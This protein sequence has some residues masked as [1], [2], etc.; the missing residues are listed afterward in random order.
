MAMS[1]NEREAEMQ[2]RAQLEAFMR[3]T[4][5][6]AMHKLSKQKEKSNTMIWELMHNEKLTDVER[7]ALVQELM[8][9]A[10]EAAKKFTDR[11]HSIEHIAS[12]T[13]ADAH[14]NVASVAT[15]M[16]HGKNLAK[17]LLSIAPTRTELRQKKNVLEQMAKSTEAVL[18]KES[19]KSSLL[20]EVSTSQAADI[21]R[22][23]EAYSAD[24]E[25]KEFGAVAQGLELA[26]HKRDAEDE[27]LDSALKEVCQ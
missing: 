16:S 10:S 20:E 2:A 4:Q 24:A 11:S 22:D 26:E 15:L 21:E 7:K 17:M 9:S 8:S 13:A 18:H 3:T 23:S 19:S 6:Q 5:G 14:V 25:Q 12:A 1:D 27:R